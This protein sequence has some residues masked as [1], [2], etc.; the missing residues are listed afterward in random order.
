MDKNK[1]M[2]LTYTREKLFKALQI[3]L[4]KMKRKEKSRTDLIF[5]PKP[6]T[7]KPK[8]TVTPNQNFFFNRLNLFSNRKVVF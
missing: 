6:Q 3:L 8:I 4:P 1:R 2:L 5:K 7:Y